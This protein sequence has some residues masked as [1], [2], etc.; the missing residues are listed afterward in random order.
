MSAPR[1]PKKPRNRDNV[2]T[3]LVIAA[4]AL[5]FFVMVFVK[6]LWLS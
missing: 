3:G 6:R 5:F 2:R 4:L 1:G